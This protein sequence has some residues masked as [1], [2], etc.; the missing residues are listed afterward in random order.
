[1]AVY[2]RGLAFKCKPG[3]RREAVLLK[4][5]EKDEESS[6]LWLLK[7]TVVAA[8]AFSVGGWVGSMFPMI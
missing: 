6:D 8:L 1:M 4:L 7:Y 3:T 5:K 2:I